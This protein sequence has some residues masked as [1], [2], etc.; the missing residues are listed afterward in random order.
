[1]HSITAAF[2]TVFNIKQGIGVV[3]QHR[4]TIPTAEWGL[5]FATTQGAG[6]FV[7]EIAR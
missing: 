4:I 3:R 1:M 6:P 2:D 5:R 7:P